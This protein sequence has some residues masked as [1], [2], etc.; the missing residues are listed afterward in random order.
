MVWAFAYMHSGPGGDAAADYIDLVRQ[1]NYLGLRGGTSFRSSAVIPMPHGIQCM[2][3][4]IKELALPM[5]VFGKCG[6]VPCQLD[7]LS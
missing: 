1:Y 6:H 5:R 2:N 7:H 4:E 3:K